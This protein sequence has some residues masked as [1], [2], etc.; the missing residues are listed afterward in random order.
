MN[1]ISDFAVVEEPAALAIVEPDKLVEEAKRRCSDWHA[2][3][4]VLGGVLNEFYLATWRFGESLLRLRED[5]ANSSHGKWMLFIS[6]RFESLGE[7]EKTRVN[8][9]NEAMN[10]CEMNPNSPTSGNFS[11][12]SVRKCIHKLAPEKVRPQLT[13]N[14]PLLP[15]ATPIHGINGIYEWH[16]RVKA[17]HAADLPLETKREYFG[18]L[19]KI[20]AEHV[21]GKEWILEA[22]A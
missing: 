3:R 15:V 22:L 18:P 1:E 14:R 12:E 11:E 21:G 10:F 17:G 5:P 8:K 9:A 2:A 6:G 13:G 19:L 4:N 20:I 7:C 16:Q